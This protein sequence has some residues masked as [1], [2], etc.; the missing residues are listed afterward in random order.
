M[1]DKNGNK[2]DEAESEPKNNNNTGTTGVHIREMTAAQ[3]FGTTSN[4][5]SI[6]VHASDITES[7][8]QSTRSVQ[9]LLAAHPVDDPI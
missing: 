6:G 5:L 4:G 1:G 8:V 9:D 3:D 2:G 7:D